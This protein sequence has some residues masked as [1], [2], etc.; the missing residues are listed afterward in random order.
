MDQLDAALERIERI[1]SGGAGE[2]ADVEFGMLD[3]WDEAVARL[4]SVFNQ[5]AHY[6]WVE[7]SVENLALARTVVSWKGD[8][9]G[10]WTPALTGDQV[11]TQFNSLDAALR[12]RGKLI[13]VLIA[14][15]SAAV[16]ISAGLAAPVTAVAA[17]RSIAKLVSELQGLVNLAAAAR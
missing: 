1:G 7:T 15:A 16:A 13:L 8:F 12:F 6:A 5:L 10:I 14:A 9:T 3:N 4:G 17:L 11:R 2:D